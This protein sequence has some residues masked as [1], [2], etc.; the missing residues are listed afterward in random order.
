MCE[1]ST[2]SAYAYLDLFVCIAA[3]LKARMRTSAPGCKSVCRDTNHYDNTHHTRLVLLLYKGAE[4]GLVPSDR[5]RSG[6]R[7]AAID[8]DG[9]FIPTGALKFVSETF[10][11]SYFSKHWR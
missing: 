5:K 11:L 7:E 4:H 2:V 6:Q 8:K 9:E 1:K 3:G 10:I